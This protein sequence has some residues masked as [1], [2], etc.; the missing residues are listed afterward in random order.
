LSVNKF[1]YNIIQELGIR[2]SNYPADKAVFAN[3]NI[4]N[5]KL[6]PVGFKIN[7]GAKILLNF[8]ESVRID[9]A[10][11]VAISSGAGA[12][13]AGASTPINLV[14]ATSGFDTTRIS[15]LKNVYSSLI[16]GRQIDQALGS[17]AAIRR[18]NIVDKLLRDELVDDSGKPTLKATTSPGIRDYNDAVTELTDL[19][20]K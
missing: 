9:P 10:S 2:Q 6:V 19:Q 17:A 4:T 1:S 3:M 5:S 18:R 13:I 11:E 12:V 7:I 8:E 14:D 16:S 20:N 15:K